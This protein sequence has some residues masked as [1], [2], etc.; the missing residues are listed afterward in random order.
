MQYFLLMF[1]KKYWHH[2][3]SVSE[4]LLPVF[5]IEIRFNI[6]FFACLVL[7]YNELFEGVFEHA[8]EDPFLEDLEIGK[9]GLLQ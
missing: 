8:A 1:C 6:L 5:V 9:R 3:F 2:F 4:S 7:F